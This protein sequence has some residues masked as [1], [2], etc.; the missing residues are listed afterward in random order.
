M[1]EDDKE[2][3]NLEEEPEVPSADPSRWETIEEDYKKKPD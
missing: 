1:T 2:R 3:S